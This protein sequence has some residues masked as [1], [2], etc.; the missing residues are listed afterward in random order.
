[1][2]DALNYINNNK[3]SFCKKIM[4]N[5]TEY[6]YRQKRYKTNFSL[7][8]IYNKEKTVISPN[9]FKKKL[10]LSD[11]LIPINENLACVVFDSTAETSYVKAA[12]NLTTILKNLDYKN[13]FFLSTVY[14]EDFDLNYLEMTNELFDRLKYAIEN[15]LYDTVIY[16]DYLI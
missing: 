2:L 9:E 8:L 6:I 13:N 4:D 1:M 16:E 15:K 5:I 14:S 7:V 12:E 3:H 11:K 10:R